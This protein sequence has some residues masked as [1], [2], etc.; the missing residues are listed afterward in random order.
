MQKPTEQNVPPLQDIASRDGVRGMVKE[1]HQFLTRYVRA[2]NEFKNKVVVE[3]NPLYGEL[4]WTPIEIADGA[5]ELITIDV[6]TAI[7]GYTCDVS[8]DQDL[9]GLQLTHYVVN[10][11]VKVILRNGTGSPVTLSAGRFRAYVWPRTLSN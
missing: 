1:L 8:Y 4:D 7:L 5:Q 11:E 3:L 2:E 6:A 9:E 10:D